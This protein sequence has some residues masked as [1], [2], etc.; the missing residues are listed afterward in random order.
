M[1]AKSQDSPVESGQ[2]AFIGGLLLARQSALST[3][4]SFP[5][6]SSWF[7]NSFGDEQTNLATLKRPYQFL[8]SLLTSLVPFEP[9]YTKKVHI[10]RPPAMPRQMKGL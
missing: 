3:T 8:V 2:E 9:V 10:T 4:P 5:S 6:Y 1:L 7:H